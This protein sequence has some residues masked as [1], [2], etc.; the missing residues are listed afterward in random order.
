MVAIPTIRINAVDIEQFKKMAEQQQWL[1]LDAKTQQEGCVFAAEP[2]VKILKT[3]VEPSND[4][5]Q[6]M[7]EEIPIYIS[8]L[9]L[10]YFSNSF[11]VQLAAKKF[12]KGFYCTNISPFV[13]KSCGCNK[14]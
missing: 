2:V 13:T 12:P 3:A 10:K 14:I 8:P 9:F 1:L 11:T 4:Y 7:I 6:M 5:S